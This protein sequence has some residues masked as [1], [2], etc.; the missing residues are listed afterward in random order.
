DSYVSVPIEFINGKKCDVLYAPS[1]PLSSFPPIL[2]EV[3][4]KVDGKF[5]TRAIQYCTLTFE[6][7]N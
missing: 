6:R 1:N 4:N 7:Y 5:L 3:Q 2:V